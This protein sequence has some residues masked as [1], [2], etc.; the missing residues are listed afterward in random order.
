VL[1]CFQ[2]GYWNPTNVFCIVDLL[3]IFSLIVD[4]IPESVKGKG[5]DE[6]SI[7]HI[8]ITAARI[9]RVLRLWRLLR[10]FGWVEVYSTNA[11]NYPQSI[12]KGIATNNI[13]KLSL[14]LVFVTAAM[15]LLEFDVGYL[16]PP[17]SLALLEDNFN[18][19]GTPEYEYL[20]ETILK[21]YP[22]LLYIEILGDV[23][24]DVKDTYDY[25]YLLRE[26]EVERFQTRSGS[27]A[28]L[29]SRRVYRTA[30]VASLLTL[31]VITIVYLIMAMIINKD[32]E[33]KLIYPFESFLYKTTLVAENLGSYER[34]DTQF[35]DPHK[36]YMDLLTRMRSHA[37]AFSKQQE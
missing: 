12:G 27:V 14:V 37:K 1:M 32:S 3:A 35:L 4:C 23:V 16:G 7:L 15:V 8:A 9:F 22:N 17:M 36:F 24:F 5:N 13:M 11:L 19:T 6:N 30:A 2:P 25:D 34:N 20:M 29:S 26:S 28:Y 33:E 10:A 21:Y 31:I 18:E